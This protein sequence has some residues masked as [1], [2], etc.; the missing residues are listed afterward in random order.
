MPSKARMTFRF[1]PHPVLKPVKPASAAGLTQPDKGDVAD[2]LSIVPM[3]TLADEKQ[4]ESVYN[5]AIIDSPPSM[6]G[7]YQDDIRALEEI[8]R[9]TDSVVVHI[10]PAQTA[11][12]APF[13]ADRKLSV[14][15][16]R[17]P[18][19][20]RELEQMEPDHEQPE[21]WSLPEDNDEYKPAGDWLAQAGAYSR[22]DNP[23]WT[24]VFLSVTA[25]IATGALFGYMVL[26]L[27]TGEPM[28]PGMQTNEGIETTVQAQGSGA[29]ALPAVTP[30]PNAVDEEVGTK[31]AT[32]AT[33]SNAA[34][35]EIP[36]EEA[37]VLQYGVFRNVNSAQ[38]AVAQLKDAGLP[39]AID[40]SDGY[41]VYAGIAATKTEAERLA[42]QMPNIEVYIKPIGGSTL[43]LSAGQRFESIKAYFTESEV[44]R[45]LI[46]QLSVGSLQDELP[47]PL[48]H[49]DADA[50][51]QAEADWKAVRPAAD[52]LSG[53][54]K[55]AAQKLEQS[56]DAALASFASYAHKTSRYHLWNAQTAIMQAELAD[57]KIREALQLAA[58]S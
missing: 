30:E 18:I 8:I 29:P 13:K 49:D 45:R 53:S 31:S 38:L 43:M 56:L 23:T 6:N 33:G 9:R 34:E 22:N 21:L 17:Q 48:A 57:R 10:P 32:G 2:R 24:R 40:D 50:L 58:R 19:V 52:E 4:E 12:A 20:V 36:A 41:R 35:A 5:H 44:L 15:Q 3:P 54:A 11:P 39:A 46:S 14:V 55:E 42:A 26:T 47:Q 51:R 1:E 27:F 37:Y 28:F 16:D 25:A 7:P